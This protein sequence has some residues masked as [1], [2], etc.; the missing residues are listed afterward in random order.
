MEKSRVFSEQ[1]TLLRLCQS[2]SCQ[3]QKQLLRQIHNKSNGV[4]GL[5]LT[6]L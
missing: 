2:E 1:E 4:R 5:Q 3:L 6:D